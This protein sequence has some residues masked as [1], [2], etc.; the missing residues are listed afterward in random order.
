MTDVLNT[1]I[2]LYVKNTWVSSDT[3]TIGRKL[4]NDI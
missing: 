3:D 4:T 2:Q 1:A